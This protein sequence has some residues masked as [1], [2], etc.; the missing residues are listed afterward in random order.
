MSKRSEFYQCRICLSWTCGLQKNVW[1]QYRYVETW[2]FQFPLAT[3]TLHKGVWI[4]LNLIQIWLVADICS[5]VPD[6]NALLELYFNTPNQFTII[7][8]FKY[9]TFSEGTQF[10]YRLHHLI[11]LWVVW[12]YLGDG[13]IS[14]LSN[15]W[16]ISRVVY[17]VFSRTLM[18]RHFRIP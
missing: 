1:S 14:T 6:K 12:N 17:Q 13:W 16:G 11:L 7:M 4:S 18:W 8:L 5:N 10:R 15:T 9:F 3:F 2:S